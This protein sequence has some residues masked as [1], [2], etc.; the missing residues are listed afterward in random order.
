M[1]AHR[2]EGALPQKELMENSAG[3]IS[4]EGMQN[5]EENPIRQS[6]SKIFVF[7]DNSQCW[8]DCCKTHTLPQRG[9]IGIFF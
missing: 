4:L 5:K 6:S 3:A 2:A 7:N 9:N 1:I 8:Q